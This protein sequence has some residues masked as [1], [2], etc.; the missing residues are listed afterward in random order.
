M[1]GCCRP[2]HGSVLG[3]QYGGK[4]RWAD[5]FSAHIQKGSHQI[6]DHVAEKAVTTHMQ[7]QR[8]RPIVQKPCRMDGSNRPPPRTQRLVSGAAVFKR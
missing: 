6:A 4:L 3:C 7:G 8:F 2:G 1:G 5:F